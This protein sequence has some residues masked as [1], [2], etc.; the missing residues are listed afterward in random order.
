MHFFWLEIKLYMKYKLYLSKF[1]RCNA[2]SFKSD[3]D[4]QYRK[5]VFP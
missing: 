1:D 4:P 2:D 3:V 5:S